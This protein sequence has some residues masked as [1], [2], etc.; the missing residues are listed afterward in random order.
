MAEGSFATVGD[1]PTAAAAP[2]GWGSGIAAAAAPLRREGR[3]ACSAGSRLLRRRASTEGRAAGW[4][5][6]S[7]ARKVASWGRVC[8]QAP[9]P[10]SILRLGTLQAARISCKLHAKSTHKTCLASL[11]VNSQ[12]SMC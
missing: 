1:T 7:D 6:S 12:V 3:D 2:A 10:V 4:C 11:V 8:V 9:R 5:C